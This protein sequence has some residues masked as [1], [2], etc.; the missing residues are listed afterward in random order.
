LTE[1]FH[2]ASPRGGGSGRVGRDWVHS[3]RLR[4]EFQQLGW[5]P[6]FGGQFGGARQLGPAVGGE[7]R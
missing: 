4:A 7:A 2:E 1:A 6:F 3:D 5:F